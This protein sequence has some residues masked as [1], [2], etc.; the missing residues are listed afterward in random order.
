MTTEDLVF[1]TIYILT[2]FA[3]IFLIL[4]FNYKREDGVFSGSAKEETFF[5]KACWVEIIM[6]IPATIFSGR[7]ALER[8]AEENAIQSEIISLIFFILTV[9]YET[10]FIRLLERRW[11]VYPGQDEDDKDED[12]Q[13]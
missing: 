12:S 7:A 5:C 2:S 6:F 1:D 10:L 3:A 13:A 8:L 11:F 4:R 9:L